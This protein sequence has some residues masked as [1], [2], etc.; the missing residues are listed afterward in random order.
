MITH[1]FFLFFRNV[2]VRERCGILWRMFASCL[3]TPYS[4]NQRWGMSFVS[5]IKLM[6]VA[7][8]F[9]KN[10]QGMRNAFVPVTNQIF[11]SN[12]IMQNSV[13][14]SIHNLMKR[15]Q[16]SHVLLWPD[17]SYMYSYTHTQLLCCQWG[18]HMIDMNL[19]LWINSFSWY[20][21]NKAKQKKTRQ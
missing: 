10:S 18:Y 3:Y 8:N 20:Y 12:S 13:L 11:W 19:Q 15:E 14:S 2:N 9:F 17:T 16:F 7:W 6:F 21:Q 4:V 1:D 5:S